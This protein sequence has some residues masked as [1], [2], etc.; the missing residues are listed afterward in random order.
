MMPVAPSGRPGIGK[1]APSDA[2]EG[3]VH[4]MAGPAQRAD[5]RT[6]V[7]RSDRPS[8]MAAAATAAAASR[9]FGVQAPVGPYPFPGDSSWSMRPAGRRPPRTRSPAPRAGPHPQTANGGARSRGRR[10]RRPGVAAPGGWA[11][12]NH[13]RRVR[14]GG[15]PSARPLPLPPPLTVYSVLAERGKAPSPPPAAA[16]SA[17]Q[18]GGGSPHR[19]V[20]CAAATSGCRR[21]RRRARRPSAA[22]RVGG[23]RVCARTVHTAPWPARKERT[24]GGGGRRK[25]ATACTPPRAGGVRDAQRRRAPPPPG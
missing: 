12:R 2:I 11:R 6:P 21:R 9:M 3:R 4:G 16:V 17:T 23:V 18:R 8:A 13:Q 19:S 25:G 24:G 14:V 20:C 10:G 5:H 15:A 7:R 22:T 1:T